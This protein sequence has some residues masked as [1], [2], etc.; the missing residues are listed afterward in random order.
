[1]NSLALKPLNS[2]RSIQK[3]HKSRQRQRSSLYGYKLKTESKKNLN[4]TII[5]F[6][7]VQLAQTPRYQLLDLKSIPH[8]HKEYTKYVFF[9]KSIL[10]QGDHPSN[11]FLKYVSQNLSNYTSFPIHIK[12]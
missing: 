12:T 11:S 3:N 4:Y 8:W 5:S 1:M 2:K 6:L 9:P 10:K 7:N